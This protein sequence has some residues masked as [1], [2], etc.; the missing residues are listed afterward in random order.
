MQALLQNRALRR[1]VAAVLLMTVIV[2]PDGAMAVDIAPIARAIKATLDWEKR[3]FGTYYGE[4]CVQR[5]RQKALSGHARIF[6]QE[7]TVAVRCNTGHP[8]LAMV[9]MFD[10]KLDHAPLFFT[11][12]LGMHPVAELADGENTESCLV[13][14]DDL[15][16]RA[17]SIKKEGIA[18]TNT[19]S[20]DEVRP[21]SRRELA[22]FIDRTIRTKYKESHKSVDPLIM[23]PYIEGDPYVVVGIGDEISLVAAPT[24]HQLDSE[25]LCGLV[26]DPHRF[27]GR[28]RQR[29]HEGWLTTAKKRLAKDGIRLERP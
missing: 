11:G 23:G 22:D 28:D 27:R 16:R 7:R 5:A 19:V 14:E 10:A 18:F 9:T 25:E 29:D 6:Q 24:M 2:F 3:W 12:K 15:V 1:S 20:K 13:T 21:L 4:R 26:L 8:V 17:E